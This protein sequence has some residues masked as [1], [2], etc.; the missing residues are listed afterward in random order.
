[1]DNLTHT[2]VGLV[3]GESAARGTHA[4][5]S[6]IA[7]ETRRNLFVSL[8]AIGSNV[9][10]LDFI[11][12]RIT[13][14]KLDYLL[15][16]R[17]HTHTILGAIALGVILY[18]C[19]EL[20]C[21]WKR[22]RLSMRDRWQLISVGLVASLLHIALDFTNSYGVHPFW[23][24]D[25]RWYYGDA[26]FIVEPLF[27]ATSAPLLFLLRSKFA[28]AFVGLVLFAGLALSIT[29]G[30][31]PAAL[32][33]VLATLTVAMIAIGKLASARIALT[34]SL[35]LWFSINAMF[36]ASSTI[37]ASR[38]RSFAQATFPNERLLDHVL[39]PLP[40][41]PFC[42]NVILVHANDDEWF[43]RRAALALAPQWLPA[44]R[45]PSRSDPNVGTA[46][47][48][49]IE[50][51]DQP[52]I[53]WI[54]EVTLSRVALKQWIEGDCAAE[55][56]MRFA[57]APWLASIE[58][59]WIVGDMRFDNERGLSFAEIELGDRTA[60]LSNV[61]PWVMPR[62]DLLRRENE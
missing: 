7:Q 49:A 55:Q 20:W 33:V 62:E 57:R 18:L 2:L 27:W 16:H 39:S 32:C 4:D 12:S 8:M 11:Q 31:V 36:M 47:V 37:A 58:N 50:A 61:P 21:R 35:A 23:P 40:A 43:I 53:E 9:P 15:H 41:N 59:E 10:D 26:V 34:V 52:A 30:M 5:P 14:S 28:K 51:V 13:G 3:V 44:E 25:N 48:D 19:C 22:Q 17:G 6:G 38:A 56:F 29:T 54:N 60:C 1:M 42:W 46:P 45:C 24:F